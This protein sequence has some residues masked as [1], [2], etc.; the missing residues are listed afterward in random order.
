MYTEQ[1]AKDISET[2]EQMMKADGAPL[3]AVGNGVVCHGA[4]GLS[5]LVAASYMQQSHPEAKNNLE[6]LSERNFDADGASSNTCIGNGDRSGNGWG[7][8]FG[9]CSNEGDDGSGEGY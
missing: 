8:D 2:H 3:I 6:K 1:E 7:Y 9:D 4:A 5:A